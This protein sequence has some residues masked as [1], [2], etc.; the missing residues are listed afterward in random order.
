[1]GEYARRKSDGQEV[2]IGTCESM[3]YIRYEDRFKVDR[4]SCSL[5]PQKCLDL[6]WRL[7]IPEEDNIKI[8]EYKYPMPAIPLIGLEFPESINYPGNL[9][10]NHECGLR[11]KVK[12]FHGQSSV[13]GTED[14]EILKLPESSFILNGIKNTRNGIRPL[15]GCNA[16]SQ[17]WSVDWVD[18]WEHIPD[19]ELKNRLHKYSTTFMEQDILG[20]N[21]SEALDGEFKGL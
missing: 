21:K 15:I 9:Y 19:G 20:W 11:I 2:K 4:S 3:Y 18:I 7:P 12:C 14:I 13:K 1:M 10:L 8:G 16:C 6:F 5:N 17:L